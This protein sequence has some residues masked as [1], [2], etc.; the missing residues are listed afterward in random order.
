MQF[1]ADGRRFGALF[2]TFILANILLIIVPSPLQASQPTGICR[3]DYL[4]WQKQGGYGAFAWSK[5]SG[6][7]S[8]NHDGASLDEVKA[9]VMKDCGKK[10][11]ELIATLDTPSDSVTKWKD[12]IKDE[13]STALAACQWLID[14]HKEKPSDL[15]ADY[16]AIG[17]IYDLRGNDVLAI[18]FYNRALKVDSKHSWA[19]SNIGHVF[20]SQGDYEKATEYLNKAAAFFH[21]KGKCDAPKCDFRAFNKT[22]LAEMKSEL[23]RMK[24]N[25][26]RTLCI[27]A[28]SVNVDSWN[29]QKTFAAS[30]ARRRGLSVGDCR[31]LMGRDRE[32]NLYESYAPAG[33]CNAA[34]N[35][36]RSA[37]VEGD[38]ASVR[39]AKRRKYD[40]GDCRL[41]LGLRK[42]PI[43]EPVAEKATALLKQLEDFSTNGKSFENVIAVARVVS[44]LK[45]ALASGTTQEVEV[46]TSELEKL[47]SFDNNFQH[48]D[49][50][51][52]AQKIDA[53]T[54]ELVVA[55]I[56]I[57]TMDLF[58]RSYITQHITS[59]K[60]QK[61]LS[62]VE[63]M[64]DT[65]GAS[66]KDL[67]TLEDD[68]MKLFADVGL[69]DELQKVMA[70]PVQHAED[71]MKLIFQEKPK[72]SELVYLSLGS[73]DWNALA[74][75][76]RDILATA[77][78]D[79]SF[80]LEFGSFAD[81]AEALLAL[82][83]AKV[84]YATIPSVEPFAEKSGAIGAG[85]VTIYLD[86]KL[87]APVAVSTC[88][89][90]STYSGQECKI[91]QNLV[92]PK[93]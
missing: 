39:E 76:K 73:D 89:L 26:S 2:C 45:T 81:E 52:E 21:P 20:H 13:S 33:V 49:S 29:S 43:D 86:T 91:V 78:D 90:L 36:K 63:Q 30:E 16:N 79:K 9:S 24:G 92:E 44:D 34:L 65:H 4:K 55:R 27:Y 77:N 80:G 41:I 84:A 7:C 53:Q 57:R 75:Q 32:V 48:F 68:N 60:N 87:A 17:N 83:R 5:R 88:L 11:C 56:K 25:D 35:A 10:D 82:R 46:K 66:G 62:I 31:V 72:E 3:T 8:F 37:F 19:L 6:R 40:L 23:D 15:A 51:L 64:K 22:M 42:N 14:S 70:N 12:C 47:T 67:V 61:L 59:D 71:A 28:T 38:G 69:Q 93:K 18:E 50:N 54:A 85:K 1:I 74:R 58:A